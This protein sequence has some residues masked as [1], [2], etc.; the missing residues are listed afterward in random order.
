MVHEPRALHAGNSLQFALYNEGSSFQSSP[1]GAR[2]SLGSLG[3]VDVGGRGRLRRLSRR[4]SRSR[5]RRR[6]ERRAYRLTSF[7]RHGPPRARRVAASSLRRGPTRRQSPRRW[8]P[9]WWPPRWWPVPDRREPPPDR[10]G[11]STG[12][13]RVAARAHRVWRFVVRL[14]HAD[15][16][17]PA[18]WRDLHRQGCHVPGRRARVLER[19]ELRRGR[20]V[21]RLAR[22]RGRR[23]RGVPHHVWPDGH[24][25][26]R[27]RRRVHRPRDLPARRARPEDVPP[28][29]RPAAPASASS[30]VLRGARRGWARGYLSKIMRLSAWRDLRPRAAIP[31]SRVTRSD[32]RLVA[33]ELREWG[34]GARW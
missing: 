20:G 25:A 30:P 4:H 5:R 10:R 27:Q 24:P 23:R 26:L 13:R 15:L 9:R 19:F 33:C 3:L 7:D 8:P 17:H 12:R 34:C 22:W 1:H 32:R 21:L 2:D 18:G 31:C 11:S 6:R 28:H 16:L 14:G 29:V